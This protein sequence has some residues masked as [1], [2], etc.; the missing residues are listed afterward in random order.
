LPPRDLSTPEAVLCR[1]CPCAAVGL[2]GCG[3]SLVE[4]L[5]RSAS[6]RILDLIFIVGS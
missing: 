1:G 6:A 5:L 3:P 2:C 4:Q